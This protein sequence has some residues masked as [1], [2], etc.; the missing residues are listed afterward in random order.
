MLLTAA[1]LYL[2]LMAVPRAPAWW[3]SLPWAVRDLTAPLAFGGGAAC[4]GLGQPLAG[5]VLILGA[6]AG[7]VRRPPGR[8]ELPPLEGRVLHVATLN[9]GM[10]RADPDL[11]LRWIRECGA[12]VVALQEVGEDLA[13]RLAGGEHGYAHHALHGAG[14]DGMA[15]LSRAP[16]EASQV[17]GAP[18]HHQVVDLTWEEAPI[19]VLNVHPYFHVAWMGLRAPAAQDVPRLVELATEGRPALVLG[20]LNTPPHTRLY[21]RF[22]EHGLGDAFA[23]VGRGAGRT[24]P[25]PLRYLWLPLPPLLRL[26]HVLHSA[27]WE[28]LRCQVGSD[29]SS[30][31]LPL[32]AALRLRP[33]AAPEPAT[34]PL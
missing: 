1:L 24:F 17:L 14:I 3:L 11:V 18:L 19:R 30:D 32:V 5:G 26:D 15:L 4:L 25:V 21:D 16:I 29:A 10:H 12:D 7:L 22:V 8:R 28:P 20:D 13:L 33:S 23:A 27:H 2:A 31:H 34:V 6:L 9:A